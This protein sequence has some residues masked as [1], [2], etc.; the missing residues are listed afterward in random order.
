MKSIL[1]NDFQIQFESS[2]FLV[3]CGA[4]NYKQVRTNAKSLNRKRQQSRRTG[5]KRMAATPFKS[6]PERH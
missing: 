4:L 1:I 5:I 3:L 2:I 6:F